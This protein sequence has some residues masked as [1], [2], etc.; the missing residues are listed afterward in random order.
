[1]C[2]ALCGGAVRVA[3]AAKRSWR[4][5]FPCLVLRVTATQGCVTA[6]RF[7]G[8]LWQALLSGSCEAGSVEAGWQ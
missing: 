4:C 1:M 5:I 2:A 3:A 7:Q 8:S 6:S